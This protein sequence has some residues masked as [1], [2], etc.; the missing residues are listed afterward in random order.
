MAVEHADGVRVRDLRTGMLHYAVGR[1][2]VYA[3]LIRQGGEILTKRLADMDEV[4]P[5]VERLA[6]VLQ[7]PTRFP[8]GQLARDLAEFATDWGRRLL[9][10][11]ELLAELDVLVIV[12]HHLLHDVPFHLVETGDGDQS[13]GT[14]LALSYCSSATL[15]TRA[16]SRN[17]ARQHV[18]RWEYSRTNAD[19]PD[20]PPAPRRC[21][22]LGV[23]VLGGN[24]PAYR[25]LAAQ[26]AGWFAE[27]DLMGER[28]DIKSTRNGDAEVLCLVCHGITDP[29]DHT[30]SGLLLSSRRGTR[31]EFP[32]SLH[33]GST[34]WFRDLPFSYFPPH[35][36]V[37]P[38]SVPNG[39]VPELMTISEV[40]TFLESR[41]ELV[42]LLGCSTA[43]GRLQSGD[44]YASI[45]YEWLQAG[46]AT[47]L[48]HQWEADFPFVADWLPR[49]L[50]NWVEKRQ[51]KAIAVR[52][53]L[54]QM[55]N[56][57]QVP[58]AAR[59]I[60]GAVVLLGDWL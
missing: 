10:G 56:S 55:L 32:V 39:S 34:F 13:V 26:A 36:T 53:A 11:P 54:N 5:K 30:N 57:G 47:V 21:R 4:V 42:M 16:V 15:F 19:P 49:F 35:L 37:N 8:A 12:P 28:V 40:R 38:E 44:S 20:A 43:T 1:D 52:D 25:Q 58:R 23:D 2:H 9:P 31:S 60:W 22:A 50:R 6:R 33:L 3:T 41:A 48:G 29:A 17:P 59:D 7:A 46:A 45:A 51:P 24:D 14:W 18:G 27:P